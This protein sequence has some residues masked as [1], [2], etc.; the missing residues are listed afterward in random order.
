MYGRGVMPTTYI[1][2]SIRKAYGCG[3]RS[4]SGHHSVEK[5]NPAC[6]I[7]SIAY[8]QNDWRDCALTSSRTA[9][10]AIEDGKLYWLSD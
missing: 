8:N 7:Q 3:H 5:V 9:R 6:D 2:V 1:K 10:R 4:A